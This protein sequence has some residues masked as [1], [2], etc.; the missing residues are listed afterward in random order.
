MSL[1]F[2]FAA[3]TIPV[4]LGISWLSI[5]PGVRIFLV[6]NYLGFLCRGGTAAQLSNEIE[7]S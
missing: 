2:T 3:L 6:S 7:A 5:C 4:S 1:R